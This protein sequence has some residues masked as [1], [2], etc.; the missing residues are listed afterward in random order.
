MRKILNLV[1]ALLLTSTVYGKKVKMNSK[2]TTK[3]SGLTCD[4]QPT[5]EELKK[6]LSPEQYE[7]VRKNG[8]ETPFKNSYWNNKKPGI[9]VDIVSQKPLFSSKDKFDSGTGWPSFTKPIEEQEV[10]EKKDFSHGMVRTE[11]RSLTANSHLGHIFTDGPGP[12]GLRYC[13][14][15]GSLKFI[16]LQDLEKNHFED[17]LYTFEKSDYEL[18][19]LKPVE[20][21]LLGGGCFWGVEELIRKLKGVLDVTTGYSG[22]TLKNPTYEIVHTGTSDNAEVVLIKYDPLVLNFN[23]ILRYFFRLHD[24]TTKNQQGNDIGTQY[25]SV[26]FYFNENQR[27]QAEKIK[28]EVERSGKWKKPVVTEITKAKAFW[29]AEEEHQD[30]LQ[31]H[32]DGYTCHYLRD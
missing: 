9:Y 2:S 4:T 1:I 7:I 24:P 10:L 31:K 12:K 20:Y 17:L 32:P 5:D 19:D 30:Y 3:N 14:N 27:K 25:R 15:S 6:T 21:A 23:E 16:P 26:I 11:A 22:G 8:T 18:A 13:I 28:E 29:K